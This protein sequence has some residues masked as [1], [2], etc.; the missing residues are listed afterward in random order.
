VHLVAQVRPPRLRV[1]VEGV[2][3]RHRRIAV[4][5]FRTVRKCWVGCSL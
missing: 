2:L 3:I 1:H 5:T 4:S